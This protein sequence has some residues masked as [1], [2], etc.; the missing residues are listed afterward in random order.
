[1]GKDKT[2]ERVIAVYPCQADEDDELSF[3]KDDIIFVTDKESD[4]WWFGRCERT[5]DEGVFPVNY[6]KPAPS[7]AVPP[8]VPPKG[9]GGPPAPAPLPAAPPP[10][11]LTPTEKMKKFLILGKIPEDR[12]GELAERMIENGV[13]T[14]ESLAPLS[15]EEVKNDLGVTSLGD[16]AKIRALLKRAPPG[17][18]P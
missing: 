15:D 18:G 3:L 10:V 17:V 1:M 9:T 13:D 12:A 7:N 6:V 2:V 8:P 5:G 11:E 4:E 16:R 14:R